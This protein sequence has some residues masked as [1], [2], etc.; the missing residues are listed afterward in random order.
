[1]AAWRTQ[2][3]QT[4]S[5]SFNRG[6]GQVGQGAPGV[7]EPPPPGVENGA[8]PS[9]Y[10]VVGVLDGDGGAVVRL[11]GLTLLRGCFIVPGLWVASRIMRVDLEPLELLGLSFA[12]SG[13]ISL[14]MIAYY[15]IG[16][17]FG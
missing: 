15:W 16:R 8:P 2:G 10:A 1:M 17:Q 14:G 12:G 3:F 6:V 11:A 7:T 9:S 5:P 4:F 13:T